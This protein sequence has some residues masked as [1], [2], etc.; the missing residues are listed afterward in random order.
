M[1]I[2]EV[3]KST[4]LISY[5][6]KKKCNETNQ[7]LLKR[8]SEI[9]KNYTLPAEPKIDR[10]LAGTQYDK[11]SVET[12]TETEAE[13]LKLDNN[14][15]KVM[16]NIEPQKTIQIHNSFGRNPKNV[17]VFACPK[18]IPKISDEFTEV[19]KNATGEGENEF[20][21]VSGE[22]LRK[23]QKKGFHETHQIIRT[24]DEIRFNETVPC[25]SQT[26]KKFAALPNILDIFR[27]S[28]PSTG[29]KE[30]PVPQPKIRLSVEQ[31]EK[32]KMGNNFN[33]IQKPFKCSFVIKRQSAQIDQESAKSQ[34]S[35]KESFEIVQAN[36]NL[37]KESQIKFTSVTENTEPE[38]SQN[39]KFQIDEN[40]QQSKQ[41]SSEE[42]PNEK[43]NKGQELNVNS[44]EQIFEPIKMEE[45]FLL[46]DFECPD[47]ENFNDIQVQE[48]CVSNSQEYFN[49]ELQAADHSSEN[50]NDE[51]ATELNEEYFEINYQADDYKE[52]MIPIE[53]KDIVN[54]PQNTKTSDGKKQCKICGVFSKQLYQHIKV[55]SDVKPFEC[56]ICCKRFRLKH[57][58]KM[59]MNIH[60]DSKPYQC[61]LCGDCF[62]D[63]KSLKSHKVS[64][65]LKENSYLYQIDF[66]I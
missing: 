24:S 31:L 36:V 28:K 30:I 14:F 7:I 9:E 19:Q 46:E 2:C 66:V 3:C 64:F 35:Q 16:R 42:L 5:Q 6:F 32:I 34:K 38:Y 1:C 47:P 44:T 51:Q 49:L 29:S 15:I 61:D 20:P 63:P 26:D 23:D 11:K 21:K 62:N 55:H 37:V 17:K 25:K 10:N 60:I 56:S 52:E 27:K 18:Q 59:H 43:V 45:V 54:I 48:N 41:M 8:F 13:I 57:N 4:I 53:S 39:E 50:R 12:Q 33:E 22:S 40:L 65:L 58:L